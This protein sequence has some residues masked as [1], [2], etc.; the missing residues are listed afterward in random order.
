MSV[1]CEG[2][3]LIQICPILVSGECINNLEVNAAVELVIVKVPDAS[4]SACMGLIRCHG[5][6]VVLK[7]HYYCDRATDI[8]SNRFQ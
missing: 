8:R 2:L 3:P 5:L 6:E 4:G 1:G 7:N